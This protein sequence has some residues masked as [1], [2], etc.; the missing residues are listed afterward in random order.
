MLKKSF[1]SKMFVFYSKKTGHTNRLF[2]NATTKSDSSLSQIIENQYINPNN[3]TITTDFRNKLLQEKLI[4]KII[5]LNPPFFSKTE[6]IKLTNMTFLL[7]SILKSKDHQ[8][9]PIL[10]EIS[11]GFLQTLSPEILQ[12]NL[13]P[14]F[15]VKL[16]FLLRNFPIEDL[17]IIFVLKEFLLKNLEIFNN[18]QIEY[19]FQNLKKFNENQ[20][21]HIGFSDKELNKVTETWMKKIKNDIPS[22]LSF[23]IML[24]ILYDFKYDD[25]E[26]YEF[27][28]DKI[29][30]HK[31]ISNEIVNFF[32]KSISSNLIKIK[33]T[34]KILKII[35]Q[36]DKSLLEMCDDFELISNAIS[37]IICR[38]FIYPEIEEIS[39]KLDNIILLIFLTLKEKMMKEDFI[40]KHSGSILML[41]FYYEHFSKQKKEYQNLKSRFFLSD[42]KITEIKSKMVNKKFITNSDYQNKIGKFLEDKKIKFEN[43]K[44]LN[45]CFVD[46]FIPDQEIYIEVFGN[47]HF[48]KRK[49][50]LDGKSKL[51]VYFLKRSAGKV[52]SIS[53]D[54]DL[55]LL[56][57]EIG[58]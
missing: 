41:S 20:Q 9:N 27:I 52:F 21:S 35:N 25:E 50:I 40:E 2:S 14:T 55:S 45:F 19:F 3:F 33:S 43:E 16:L 6:K 47:V 34:N 44:F 31:M 1:F 49:K 10:K 7:E 51:R 42:E 5:P 28:L 29:L 32:I 30:Y 38:E 12:N 53:N 48:L 39:I 11:T 23:K 24:T 13:T 37:F 56:L 57:E 15:S 22:E 4:W 36:F 26:I 58:I 46:F 8:L 17:S 54:Q 18:R